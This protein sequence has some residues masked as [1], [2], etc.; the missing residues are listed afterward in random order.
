MVL[1]GDLR[2]SGLKTKKR[3]EKEIERIPSDLEGTFGVTN[4]LEYRRTI[5][6][7]T[8]I[9]PDIPDRCGDAYPH[10]KFRINDVLCSLQHKW[11]AA[12]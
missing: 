9:R 3:I 4:V 12:S 11:P 10:P 5:L 1:E 8:I 6:L 2:A 7:F